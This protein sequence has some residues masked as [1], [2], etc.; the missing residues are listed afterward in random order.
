[1]KPLVIYHGNCAD[2]FA[3]AWCF[4][5]LR[6]GVFDFHP[7]M[8]GEEPPSVLGRDVYFV[9][10]SYK[11]PVVENMLKGALSVTLIDHHISAIKD[12]EGL[13]GLK[14]FADIER[15]G[16]MLAWDYLMGTTNGIPNGR[17]DTIGL[18]TVPKLLEH[19]Q[20]RD[21]WRFALPMT[22][23]VQSNLFSY[24]YTFE[25]YDKLMAL[26]G[27]ELAEFASD[28][29]AI[30][31]KQ[32][33]DLA[34]LLPQ[35]TRIMEIGGYMAPVANL[36]YTMASEAGNIMSREAHETGSA[37]FAA[38]YFDTATHRKFSLRSQ[39]GVFDVSRIAVQYGGG[40]HAEAAG[41]MVERS[42]VLAR[43]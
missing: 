22:R 32:A 16:A 1:M 10:F 7:G 24:P 9:D 42:H 25:L 33:K 30:D 20:D 31:R 13:P 23:E 15:S 27:L 38:T 28:G 36:P 3:A 21:L 4:H 8:H 34:E 12:L 35:L 39:K 43:S 37:P 26:K 18:R 5:H 19:I 17:Y 40:G 14:R 29:A 41:F 11:R 2:G 6:P